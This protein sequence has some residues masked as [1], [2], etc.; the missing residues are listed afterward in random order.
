[1]GDTKTKE[2][3]Y[4]VDFQIVE[5]LKIG[6]KFMKNTSRVLYLR[7]KITQIYVDELK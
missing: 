2:L 7:I 5:Y 3:V 6:E 4:I 1:M